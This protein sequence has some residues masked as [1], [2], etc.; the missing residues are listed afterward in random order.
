MET[1]TERYIVSLLIDKSVSHLTRINDAITDIVIP[2]IDRDDILNENPTH[3]I[4]KLERIEKRERKERNERIKR[5]QNQNQ[6][7]NRNRDDEAMNDHYNEPAGTAET[8][9]AIKNLLMCFYDYDKEKPSLPHVVTSFQHVVYHIAMKRAIRETMHRLQKQRAFNFE[10]M[11]DGLKRNKLGKRYIMTAATD[12]LCF[13]MSK[14]RC[15]IFEPDATQLEQIHTLV[16]TL[17]ECVKGANAYGIRNREEMIKGVTMRADL[18]E[19]IRRKIGKQSQ[20]PPGEYKDYDLSHLV[21][22]N[23]LLYVFYAINIGRDTPAE[24]ESGSGWGNFTDIEVKVFTKYIRNEWMEYENDRTNGIRMD[25][26]DIWDIYTYRNIPNLIIGLNH[27]L[28]NTRNRTKMIVGQNQESDIVNILRTKS[29][30][31]VRYF[32]NMMMIYIREFDEPDIDNQAHVY[33]KDSDFMNVLLH[34]SIVIAVHEMHADGHQLNINPS[35][36]LDDFVNEY[37]KV[38]LTQ[39]QTQTQYYPTHRYQSLDRLLSVSVYL[40]KYCILAREHFFTVPPADDH[41]ANPFNRIFDLFAKHVTQEYD[42]RAPRARTPGKKT[43]THSEHSAL[44]DVLASI[45]IRRKFFMELLSYRGR[46][47]PPGHSNMCDLSHIVLFNT[48]AFT[49]YICKEWTKYPYYTAAGQ[50][51][52]YEDIPISKWGRV[53]EAI[54][55]PQPGYNVIKSEGSDYDEFGSDASYRAAYD[56]YF[57]RYHNQSAMVDIHDIWLM[58]SR[59]KKHETANEVKRAILDMFD[60]L[61]TGMFRQYSDVIYNNLIANEEKYDML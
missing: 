41:N 39:T 45:D 53:N 6:N 4:T 59:A 20:R 18:F 35:D 5:E 14:R 30:K 8:K 33:G 16:N 55:A 43:G 3:I 38:Y 49:Y 50:Q 9:Q 60:E 29:V 40:A 17:I 22:L 56:M 32:Y 42:R 26:N 37:R 58:I 12:M 57:E 52:K 7:R 15:E 25:M 28:S 13:F 11:I 48:M 47:T 10:D 24:K 2:C 61:V 21:M 34:H 19:V 1:T 54:V 23:I 44:T 27:Y 46:K 31:H 36:A 51:M